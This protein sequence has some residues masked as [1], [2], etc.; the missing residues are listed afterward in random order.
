MQRAVD[1][2]RLVVLAGDPARHGRIRLTPR[3]AV[4]AWPT[5][6]G[7]E[8]DWYVQP[9]PPSPLAGL[10]A[11][12]PW[13]SLPP[14]SSAVDL[15]PDSSAIVVLTAR[16]ARRGTPQPIVLLTRRDGGGA[17]Q[18]TVAAS[19]LWRWSFRGGAAGLAYRSFI[20]S[21]AD[22]L[23]GGGEG[24]GERFVPVALETPNGLP[25]VWR[26]TGMGSPQ[27]VRISLQAGPAER[28]DTV[29]FDADGRAELRL[30]PG[31]YRY[32]ADDGGERGLV[33]VETYSAEWRPAAA[34]LTAQAGL[35]AER[36]ESVGLRDRWWLFVIAVAAFA[37][38]WAWRRRMGLP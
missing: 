8:G 33:A 25:L 20:A 30:P 1:A 3:A 28:V 16:L 37:A 24:R 7:R 19:G 36:R 6:R 34:V 9:P 22:W 31:V 23:L 12:L 11:G 38:E 2:A 26:W 29:R 15:L 27:D 21:L 4:L 18:A 10:L 35:P 17:R 13:D 14:A 5:T 32:A